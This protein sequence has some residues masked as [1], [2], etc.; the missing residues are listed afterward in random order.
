MVPRQ[1]AGVL[2]QGAEDQV[3]SLD[4]G[5]PRKRWSTTA[6]D[7]ATADALA[8]ELG[9]PRPLARV[10]AGRGLTDVDAAKRY[11]NPRLSNI[12]DPCLLPGVEDGAARLWK[13]LDAGESITV[14]GDYDADGVTGTALM[15]TVLSRLGGRVSHFIPRRDTDGY[16]LSE[17][18]LARCLE[19]QEPSLV[20]SVDCGTCSGDAVRLAGTRGVDVV[21]TDHHEI[22]GEVAPAVAVVNPRLR[23]GGEAVLA[24]VGVAFKLCH[25]VIKMGLAE[26][27]ERASKVD[28]RHYLDW[29]A[30][31]TV[32][33]VVPLV[34]ENRIL[35][36]HGLTRLSGCCSPG[37]EALK[38]VSRVKGPVRG[39][40]VGFMLAPR[41]NA[42]GRLDS[43]E[44]ALELLLTNDAGRAEQLAE[45]LNDAN[46]ERKRVEDAI[47]VEAEREIDEYFSA[48]TDFGL[49]VAREGW[50][51]GTLGIVASRLSKRYVRPAVVIG[52]EEDGRG[53]GSCR[54]IE[55]LDMVAALGECAGELEKFGGHCMAAGLTVKPGRIAS[56]KERFNAV[57]AV[58]LEGTDL[59]PVERV[60]A[61]LDALGEA[62]TRLFEAT[63]QLRPFGMANPRPVW[64]VRDVA[65]LGAPRVVGGK[66][67]KMCVA[68]GGSRMDGIAFGMGDREVPDG[69]LDVVFQLQTNTYMGQTSLQLNIRDFRPT[70][71]VVGVSP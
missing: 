61:W 65:V 68:G 7:P 15:T 36:R 49:V 11:L 58:R 12:E 32:A 40:H 33:D 67:L 10:L 2:A 27:R 30:L 63:E 55:G 3:S 41:L 6:G 59:R 44:A 50:H 21:V 8:C 60:D 29:V 57:C 34:G 42:V 9:M 37:V 38:C 17:D 45:E 46:E 66:H 69:N 70:S 48:E 39:H 14:F 25:A 16:G 18:A 13:A 1:E 52:I 20:V 47:R 24:G 28:L 22:A 26:G 35:V 53:R 4:P 71:R 54:S 51:I 23:E 19:Q 31:G 64:G 43:A 5:T 62:D 56:F